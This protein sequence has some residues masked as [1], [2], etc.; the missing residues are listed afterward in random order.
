MRPAVRRQHRNGDPP[1]ESTIIGEFD[2]RRGA[3][4]AVEHVVQECGVPQSDV[5]IQPRAAQ[6]RPERTPPEPARRMRR[7]RRRAKS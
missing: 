4:L 6:T 1:L 2:T 3:E 5:F 7:S